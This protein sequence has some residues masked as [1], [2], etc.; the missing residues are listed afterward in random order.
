MIKEVKHKN[1]LK[2]KGVNKKTARKIIKVANEIGY[3]NG[4]GIKRIKLVIYKRNGHII[5]NSPFFSNLLESTERACREAGYEMTICNLDRRSENFKSRLKVLRCC[6]IC[7]SSFLSHCRVVLM[8]IISPLLFNIILIS[9]YI[10]STF[11][12]KILLIIH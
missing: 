6:I 11:F 3:I 4:S 5:D 8:F 2:K 12:G 1:Y 9:L 10:I 7:C